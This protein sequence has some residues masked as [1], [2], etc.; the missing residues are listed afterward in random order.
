MRIFVFSLYTAFFMTLGVLNSG[1]YAHDNG[2]G[3]GIGLDVHDVRWHYDNDHDDQWRHDH[4]WRRY[5]YDNN[6]DDAW[7]HDHPWHDDDRN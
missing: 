6:H 2:A 3:V 5:D 7:R 1:C 4:P